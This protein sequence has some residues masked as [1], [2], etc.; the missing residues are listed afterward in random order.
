MATVRRVVQS[1]KVLRA[2]RPR[3]S[4][5]R[6]QVVA[7][8]LALADEHGLEALSMPRLAAELGCGVMTLYRYVADKNDLL[9]AMAQSGLAG[10]RLSRPLPDDPATVM[11][12][13]GRALRSI[14]RTHPSLPMIFLSRPI[15]GPGI[16][17]GVEALLTALAR[18][19]VAPSV[20]VRAVYA[21][22]IYTTGFAAWELP[23]AGPGA[24]EAY[25]RSWRLQLAD[26]HPGEYPLATTVVEDLVGVADEQQYD[27]GL[28]SLA[29]GLFPAEQ[30]ASQAND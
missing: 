26:P 28:T 15:V 4:L 2:R 17:N 22:L 11:V 21:V 29:Q 3:G 6:D 5:S 16:L 10:L 14:L 12:S 25:A 8:A 1:G 18:C 7:A 9:D 20:G 30:A 23:R 19:G 24:G 27:Y 13:W